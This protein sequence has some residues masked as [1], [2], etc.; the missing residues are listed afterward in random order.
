RSH[1]RVAE[2][3]DETLPV[4]RA[5]PPRATVRRRDTTERTSKR[6]QAQEDQVRRTEPTQQEEDRLGRDEQRGEPGARGRSPNAL[7]GG[8]AEGSEDAVAPSAAQRVANRQRGVLPRRDDHQ[9]R[10]AEEAQK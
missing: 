7:G 2:I 4:G 3:A 9:G 6:L 1:L 8:Y 10:D 5:R